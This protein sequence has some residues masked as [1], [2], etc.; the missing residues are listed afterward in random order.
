LKDTLLCSAQP[1]VSV[2]LLPC[3]LKG[4]IDRWLRPSAGAPESCESSI[5]MTAT[6]QWTRRRICLCQLDSGVNQR[7]L[8]LCEQSSTST[9]LNFALFL[10]GA[11]QGAKFRCLTAVPGTR[12]WI[13]C[14]AALNVR[15][16][17][18]HTICHAV[19]ARWYYGRL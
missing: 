15:P 17:T 12:K 10:V 16:H 9:V 8:S 18:V 4:L 14:R 2:A 13:Y 5:R 7:H 19:A 6:C 11:K 3:S 1:C